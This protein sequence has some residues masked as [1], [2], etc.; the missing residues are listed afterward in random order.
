[1]KK[2]KLF[3]FA[4]TLLASLIFLGSFTIDHSK[5]LTGN[6]SV[7]GG[8]TTEERGLK[9]TFV[10]NAVSNNQGTHGH[11][12]YQFR[13][14]DISI[15]MDLDCLNINGNRA[16]LSGT[17]SSVSGTNIPGFIFVGQRASFTVEDNGN[18]GNNDKISDLIL[19][20][21][22]SCANNWSTY[23]FIQGNISIKE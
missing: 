4:T 22:A 8:G 12:V 11:L 9:S 21:G 7:N 20:G 6:S 13:G 3:L 2:V 19:F 1:M 14:G 23:L 18:G 17:V 16:T 15:H 10:F 5:K